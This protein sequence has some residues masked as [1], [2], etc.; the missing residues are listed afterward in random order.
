[1]VVGRDL[2][3]L[4]RGG[5]VGGAVPGMSEEPVVGDEVSSVVAA[6]CRSWAVRCIM[7]A[8]VV[9]C[10]PMRVMCVCVGSRWM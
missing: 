7:C 3:C 5:E 1:M 9:G 2:G 10:C 6:Y 8:S 4:G